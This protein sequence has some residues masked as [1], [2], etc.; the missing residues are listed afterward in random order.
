MRNILRSLQ[1]DQFGQVCA[2]AGGFK[3]CS[4]VCIVWPCALHAWT[5]VG[6]IKAGMQERVGK[7][8]EPVPR[9]ENNT[10]CVGQGESNSMHTVSFPVV[11]HAVWVTGAALPSKLQ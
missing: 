8:Q 2:H 11:T 4:K 3:G 7:M 10:A 1:E 9:S 6:D 5:I